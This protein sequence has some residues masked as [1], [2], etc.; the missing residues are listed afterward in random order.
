MSG[1]TRIWFIAGFAL[2]VLLTALVMKA[3]YGNLFHQLNEVS[4]ASG[5]DGLQTYL[6]IDYHVRH[7][8]TYMFCNS[9]NF[10][11]SVLP[12]QN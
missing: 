12:V 3:F 4:F 7:D 11:Y 2:T 5:G 1:R 10:F 8:S 6:N 9:M